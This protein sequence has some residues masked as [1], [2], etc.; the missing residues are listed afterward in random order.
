MSSKIKFRLPVILLVVIFSV[1]LFSCAGT[2]TVKRPV[3]KDRDAEVLLSRNTAEGYTPDGGAYS[4]PAT[5]TQEELKFLLGSIM[6][7]DKA[8][9]GWSESAPVFSG[10]ELDGIVPHFVE[11]FAVAGTGEDIIFRSEL[12]KSGA[13]FASRRFTD[14]R[15]FVRNGKLNCMFANANVRPDITRVYEGDPRKLY[16]GALSRLVTNSWQTLAEDE[17]GVH[18]NWVIMDIE[19]AYAE[20]LGA[21]KTLIRRNEIRREIKEKR[22]RDSADWEDWDAGQA[23]ERE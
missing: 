12:A 18:H 2:R 7:Q 23:V 11:A 8:L 21:E 9:I 1:A 14:G 3:F 10:H 6:H 17:K 15:M 22:K 5:F 16:G 19:A 20:K 4:H 13:L